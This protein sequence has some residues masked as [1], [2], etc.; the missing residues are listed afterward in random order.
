MLTVLTLVSAG[1]LAHAGHPLTDKLTRYAEAATEYAGPVARAQRKADANIREYTRRGEVAR[2]AAQKGQERQHELMM[3]LAEQND[4]I[5]AMK[6]AAEAKR[7]AAAE[8]K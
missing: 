1:Y 8:K 4:R 5:A 6:A 7:K 2:A 3:Q